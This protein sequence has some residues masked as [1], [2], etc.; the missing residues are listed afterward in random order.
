[1]SDTIDV[2]VDGVRVPEVYTLDARIVNTGTETI[3]DVEIQ[4]DVT[5]AQV[6]S[7]DMPDAPGEMLIGA[8]GRG[9]TLEI[10]YINRAEV[11]L[12]RLLLDAKPTD[13]TPRFRQPDVAFRAQVAYETSAVETVNRVLFAFARANVLFHLSFLVLPT[14]RR[15]LKDLKE[16]E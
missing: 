10:S 7:A 9:A 2:F 6:L 4:L 3:R 16:R 12:A 5:G 15:Y 14:Y 11:F 1:M 13:V 8:S